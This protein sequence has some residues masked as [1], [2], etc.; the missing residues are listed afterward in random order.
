MPRPPD[1]HETHSQQQQ[2]LTPCHSP[3][4]LDSIL[5]PKREEKK[6]QQAQKEKEEDDDEEGKPKQKDPTSNVVWPIPMPVPPHTGI[7]RTRADREVEIE[8][9]RIQRKLSE[10][11]SSK[12]QTLYGK[13][14]EMGSTIDFNDK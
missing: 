7:L 6:K 1:M 10:I 2:Q 5:D 8:N 14:K 13:M 3:K 9:Q 4:G 12:R 11:Y